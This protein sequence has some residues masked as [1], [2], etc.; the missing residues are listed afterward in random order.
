MFRHIKIKSVVG[1]LA[2]GQKRCLYSTLKILTPSEDVQELGHIRICGHGREKG[3]IFITVSL[4]GSTRL[5]SNNSAFH[6]FS[7]EFSFVLLFIINIFL[8]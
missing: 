8:L 6:S 4:P 5:S 3:A 7:K 1:M 2:A